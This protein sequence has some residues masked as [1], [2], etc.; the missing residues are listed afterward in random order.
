MKKN[1]T[2]VTNFSVEL[3]YQML[4]EKS[5]FRDE[6]CG[7]TERQRHNFPIMH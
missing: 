1:Y 5:T 7:C 3:Q 6:I 4:L 2:C